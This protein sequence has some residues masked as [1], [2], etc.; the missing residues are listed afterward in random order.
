[1]PITN[2]SSKSIL[3]SVVTPNYN[4]GKKLL[5]AIESL[6]KN[7]ISFEHIIIDDCSTDDSFSC[8]ERLENNSSNSNFVLFKNPSNMGP[9]ASRNKG[10]D[11]ARGQY[12]IFLDADDYF[13]DNALDTLHNIIKLKKKPDVV[14]FKHYMRTTT[15]YNLNFSSD[16]N[17]IDLIDDPIREYLLDKIISSP[18]CKCIKADLA[19]SYR[20]PDLRVSEDAL[21]NLDIFINAKEVFR[22]N[23]TLYIFDKIGENSLTRKAF[24]KK[25]FMSFHKGWIS[26]ETKAAKE[27][28]ID[29][30]EELLANRKI[31]F[32]AL[33]Y[34][35]RLV[36]NSDKKTDKVIVD[37]I[38]NTILK[39]I[40]LAR[41][42]LNTKIKLLCFLFYFFPSLTI[43][44]LKFYK[45]F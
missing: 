20:F 42:M 27:L 7:S 32:E 31:R 6:K 15:K 29:N 14:L 28:Q 35:S 17:N 4:S 40:V 30:I 38:R 21:Y 37:S 8:V 45:V 24:N 1:M 16:S 13:L 33:Y 25:E 43:N 34:I 41:H 5:R 9:A 18:W 11:V 3:F 10:L 23:S 12:I 26:F 39:N 2:Q 36:I 44:L 19:K 22:I